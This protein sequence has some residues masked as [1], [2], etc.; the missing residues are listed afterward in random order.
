MEYRFLKKGEVVEKGDEVKGY[1]QSFTWHPCEATVGV[2]VYADKLFLRPVN[3]P[4][5]T[6]KPK[7]K[8]RPLK[9][10]EIIRKGDKFYR[11]YTRAW[12]LVSNRSIGD[13]VF[14]WYPFKFKR[15]VS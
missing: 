13:K 5:E 3:N 7:A 4:V 8:Y 6:K 12:V 10:N 1:G 14:T 15:K 11:G 2:K 9:D